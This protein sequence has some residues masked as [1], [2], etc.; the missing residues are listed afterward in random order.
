V[1]RAH[2]RQGLA[3]HLLRL[4]LDDCHAQQ[5]HDA[6]T[7]VCCFC[8]PSSSPLHVQAGFRESEEN[9]P[10][11]IVQ[12]H[13]KL[14]TTHAQEPESRCFQWTPPRHSSP[15]AQKENHS[16]D[17]CSPLAPWDSAFERAEPDM[18]WPC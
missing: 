18:E 13:L 10:K 17:G 3:L 9:P 6:K 15:S 8:D 4:A 16:Q 14:R 7:R 2:Q 1:D 11:S 12:R 5:Q